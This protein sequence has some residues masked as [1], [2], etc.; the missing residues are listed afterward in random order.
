MQRLN[1]YQLEA[2]A[3]KLLSKSKTTR[4]RKRRKKPSEE[5]IL[6]QNKT[7]IDDKDNI[8]VTI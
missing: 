1:V 7:N 6:V 4:S 8:I 5:M 2:E 3:N